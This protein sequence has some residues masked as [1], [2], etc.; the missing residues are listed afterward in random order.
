MVNVRRDNVSVEF[1]NLR[2]DKICTSDLKIFSL[3]YSA[4]MCTFI[5][6][7]LTVRS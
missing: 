2:Q 4:V 5:D 6:L 7:Y 1:C 3:K